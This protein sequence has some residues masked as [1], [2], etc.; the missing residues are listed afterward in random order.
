MRFKLIFILL[1]FLSACGTIPQHITLT[2]QPQQNAKVGL[3][4]TQLP[5]AWAG[6]TGSVGM[7]DYAIISAA[8]RSLN[9]H[10]ETLNFEEEFKFFSNQIKVILEEKGF[11]VILIDEFM[12]FEFALKL[13]AHENGISQNDYE[14][15]K[16]KYELNYLLTI[17]LIKI[18]TVRPYY[19]FVPTAP[20]TATVQIWGEL[21]ELNNNSVHWYH[22]VSS[23][24]AIPEPWDEKNMAFPNLTNSIYVTLDNAM[25]KI[26]TVLQYPEASGISEE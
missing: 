23:T 20:P 4:I 3:L 25:N 10:L 7:L 17:R 2:S 5:K 12:P 6:Y 21:V 22:Q 16:E 14:I 26:L 8:N 18:G 13:K 19:S 9:K 11:S 24:N 15:Y 1:I